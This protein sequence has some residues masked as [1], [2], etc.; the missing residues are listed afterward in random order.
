MDTTT[1]KP[2]LLIIEDNPDTR[3]IYKDVF[4]RDGFEVL[5]AEDGDKGLS[6]AQA[7]MPDAILL[8]LML[9]KLSGFDLLKRLRDQKETRDIPVM[10]FSALADTANRKKAAELGVTEYSV[11][12]FNPPKQ[13]VNRVRALL[14]SS[15]HP[16]LSDRATNV[17]PTCERPF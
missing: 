3:Q 14:E 15:R 13:V 17:C 2:R 4:E 1:K 9:P 16:G 12:A 10:I 5:L 7:T 8:D 6:Y 11:K